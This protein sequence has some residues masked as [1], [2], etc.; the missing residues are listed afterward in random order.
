VT[1]VLLWWQ[2]DGRL[3]ERLEELVV[4]VLHVLGRSGDNMEL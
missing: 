4:G 2:A 1:G 3:P